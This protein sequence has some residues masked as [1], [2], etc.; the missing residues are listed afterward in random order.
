M[1]WDSIWGL[2]WDLLMN[3]AWASRWLWKIGN[4]KEGLWLLVLVSKYAIQREGLDIRSIG[5]N[6]S[7]HLRGICSIKKDFLKNSRF[8]VRL[9]T[10]YL[11]GFNTWKEDCPLKTKFSDLL[12]VQGTK[13]QVH[14]VS[15]LFCFPISILEMFFFQK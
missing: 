3:Q 13:I 10:K 15:F 6:Q 9:E 12:I 8:Y 7:R 2:E 11:F 4:V 1:D 14:L 5:R